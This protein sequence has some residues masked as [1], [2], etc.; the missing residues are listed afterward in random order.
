MQKLSVVSVR[1]DA[2]VAAI[3]KVASLFP[4]ALVRV[5]LILLLDEVIHLRRHT[6]EFSFRLSNLLMVNGAASRRDATTVE[7]NVANG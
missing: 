5:F 6:F 7:G 2:G 4:V 1:G 3:E